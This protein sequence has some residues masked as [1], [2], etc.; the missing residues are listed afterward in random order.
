VF[1]DV[2]LDRVELD[3]FIADALAALLIAYH[4]SVVIADVVA[5]GIVRKV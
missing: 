4:P 3:D 2:G 1:A 5:E